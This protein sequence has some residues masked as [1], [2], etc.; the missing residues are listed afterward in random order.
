MDNVESNQP[1]QEDVLKVKIVAFFHDIDKSNVAQL[2]EKIRQTQFK[3]KHIR[4][5][6]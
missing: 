4:Q 2:N 1:S 3:S 6:N 5:K